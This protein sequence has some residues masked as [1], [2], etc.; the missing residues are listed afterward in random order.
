MRIDRAIK[1]L[2]TGPP[3]SSRISDAD[4]EAAGRLAIEALK[5]YQLQRQFPDNVIWETLPG[6]T[7]N[8]G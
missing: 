6:E 1:I 5:R 8:R 4:E 7:K 2:E 3:E